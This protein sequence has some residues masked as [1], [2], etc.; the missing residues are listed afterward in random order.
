MAPDDSR[1][2]EAP[3]VVRGGSETILFVEDD[4]P[5][6]ESTRRTRAAHGY[7]VLTAKDGVT[8]LAAFTGTRAGWTS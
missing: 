3:P 1:R 4:E 5:L 7:T 8:A 6:R 2:D